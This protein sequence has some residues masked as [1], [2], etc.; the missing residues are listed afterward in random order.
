MKPPAKKSKRKIPAGWVAPRKP[1][2]PTVERRLDKTEAFFDRVRRM[3]E[4]RLFAHN[5]KRPSAEDHSA[6]QLV[7]ELAELAKANRGK[8]RQPFLALKT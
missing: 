4:R 7:Q 8:I 2:R 3:A 6:V 5:L 1:Y